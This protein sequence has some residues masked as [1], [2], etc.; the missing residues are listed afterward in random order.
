MPGGT[1]KIRVN[2]QNEFLR[3]SKSYIKARL[4]L[5]GGATK[6]AAA[7]TILGCSAVFERIVTSIGGKQIEDL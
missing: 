1:I 5:T 7:I 2:S 4:R 3:P 6:A